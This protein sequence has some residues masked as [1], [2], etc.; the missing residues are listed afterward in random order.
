MK[1]QMKIMMKQIP[2]ILRLNLL[3]KVFSLSPVFLAIILTPQNQPQAT[4]VL[5]YSVDN[6]L[7]E[8]PVVVY[9]QIVFI[10][11]D[12]KT[13]YRTAVLE[14]R[15]IAKSPKLFESRRDFFIP[16]FNRALPDKKTVE[17][18]AASPE[19]RLYEDVLVFLRPYQDR[20]LGQRRRAD[21]E[22]LFALMGFHQGAMRVYED[23]LGIRR[24]ARWDQD[25][26]TEI[27][28]HELVSSRSLS[29]AKKT[30]ADRLEDLVVPVEEL[31]TLNSLLN[32][33]RA[34]AGATQ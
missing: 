17:R 16:L 12:S 4:M 3:I 9:G 15:E 10:E 14:A 21:G 25:Q 11:T 6:L 20:D 2:S 23:T 28:N 7:K 26:P 32:Q 27:S 30:K 31:P 1:S 29:D 33:A 22:P 18:V 19:F 8:A 24:A 34:F 5:P 13:G